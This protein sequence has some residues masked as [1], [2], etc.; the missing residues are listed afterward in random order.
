MHLCGERLRGGR[1]GEVTG[2]AEQRTDQ[3]IGRTMAIGETAP[4]EIRQRSVGETLT[5]CSEQP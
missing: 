1:L 2:M 3:M 4:F 5:P